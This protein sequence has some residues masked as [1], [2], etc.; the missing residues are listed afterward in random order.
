MDVGLWVDFVG[1]EGE[2]F[3][4]GV[5]AGGAIG[6]DVEV[7]DECTFDKYA[8]GEFAGQ[9]VERLVGESGFIWEGDGE[10]A[11]VARLGEAYGDAGAF[12]EFVDG[13]GLGVAQADDQDALGFDAVGSVQEKGFAEGGLEFA[14]A[15]PWGGGFGDGV[16]GG[17]D[18]GGRRVAF[19]RGDVD[20]EDGEQRRGEGLRVLELEG[21]VH[22]VVSIARMLIE[23]RGGHV[24]AYG[25]WWTRR[26]ETGRVC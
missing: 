4:A 8:C 22:V 1:D 12:A 9:G 21:S 2:C 15:Q 23:L 20:G 3:D 26:N 14:V 7:G 19:G 6:V 16:G 24:C 11:D 25:K 13:K 10:R 17:E 5:F 18:R